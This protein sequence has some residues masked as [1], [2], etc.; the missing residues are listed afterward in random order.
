MIAAEKKH[1]HFVFL[2]DDSWRQVSIVSAKNN[3]SKS[4]ALNELL[5]RKEEPAEIPQGKLQASLALLQMAVDSLEPE[6][7]ITFAE[8]C[9]LYFAE[10]RKHRKSSTIRT[11]L[12]PIYKHVLAVIGDTLMTEITRAD[13]MDIRDS[14]VEKE[15]RSSYINQIMS[16]ISQVFE[17]AMINEYIVKDP[18]ANIKP[19]PEEKSNASKTYHRA[20]DKAKELVP[21]MEELTHEYL[22]LFICFMLH[23]GMRFGEVAA[24]TADDIS[25]DEEYIYVRRTL[26]TDENNH[27]V[28]GDSPKTPSSV[29]QIPMNE[30]L[31]EIL[32]QIEIPTDGSTIFKSARGKMVSNSAVNSAIK[33][34]LKRLD[35]KGMHI[36]HFTSHALRDTFATLYAE[37]HKAEGGDIKTLQVLLGHSKRGITEDL[38][39]HAIENNKRAGMARMASL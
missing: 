34:T 13:L 31:K 1:L 21:F 17:Y 25:F 11:D 8:C 19:L 4:D 30:K 22:Y 24:L 20:L 23:T 29:R 15:L 14:L 2:T 32:G 10:K 5:C 35:D 9:D 12:K 33:R 36:D 3:V 6:H 38:Y 26:M 16:S 39:V 37:A 7:T 18:T 28:M 27:T